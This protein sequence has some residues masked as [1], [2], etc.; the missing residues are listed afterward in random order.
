MM[1]HPDWSSLPGEGDGCLVAAYQRDPDKRMVADWMLR[2]ASEETFRIRTGN[3][4]T[5]YLGRSS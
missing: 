5:W 3:L 1:A 2:G 4:S